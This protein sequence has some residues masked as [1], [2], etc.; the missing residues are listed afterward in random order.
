MS[1]NINS[2][3]E[4]SNEKKEETKK[5]ELQEVLEVEESQPSSDSLSEGSTLVEN[6]KNEN[7]RS[8]AKPEKELQKETEKK[9]E[10]TIKEIDVNLLKPH[11]QNATIYGDEDVSELVALIKEAGKIIVPLVINKD[12]VI[13]SGHRR[14]K[15]AKKLGLKTVPCEVKN[16]SSPEDELQE[17]IFYNQTREKTIEQKFRESMALEEVYASEAYKRKIAKLKQNKPV[18]DNSAKSDETGTTP[19]EAGATRDKVA[20]KAGLSSGRTYERAK[21]VIKKIDELKRDE[22]N[23]DAELLAY[24][25]KKSVSGAEYLATK[26]VSLSEDDKHNL[27]IGKVRL[28]VIVAKT[29]NEDVIT[30]S[31]S[32]YTLIMDQLN[33]IEA[34]ITAL[35]NLDLLEE[36]DKEKQKIQSKI[37]NQIEN[38]SELLETSSFGESEGESEV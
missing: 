6:D 15:A 3:K 7:V 20:Q 35:S 17:L 32:G 19:D 21:T 5:D 4:S 13:I 14:W 11:P 24:Y 10:V 31:P 36:G 1:K 8:K 12:L 37:A 34:A 26:I 30:K 22:K 29:K 23:E 9:E 25:L 38:L 18:K 28:G 27:R 2:T 16:Y 33:I